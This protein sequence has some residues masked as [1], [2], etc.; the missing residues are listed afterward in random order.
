MT[1]SN[2]AITWVDHIILV[3]TLAVFPSFC[4][5][6]PVSLSMCYFI[7]HWVMGVACCHAYQDN[8]SN[9][10]SNSFSN[11]L[12]DILDSFYCYRM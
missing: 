6:A 9:A 3:I 1:S 4:S 5:H 11:D 8:W 10:E 2:K 12:V 7:S